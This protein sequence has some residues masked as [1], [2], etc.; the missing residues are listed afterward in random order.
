MANIVRTT[1][2]NDSVKAIVLKNKL[3]SYLMSSFSK[4][5]LVL[6]DTSLKVYLKG[7]KSMFSYEIPLKEK[8]ETPFAVLCD[9]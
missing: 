9:I 2:S 8:V 5:Y 4:S 3:F 1:L 6:Q 7:V